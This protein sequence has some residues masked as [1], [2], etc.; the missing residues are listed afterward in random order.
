MAR[1]PKDLRK[2][3]REDFAYGGLLIAL[4]ALTTMVVVSS[5]TSRRSS[6]PAGTS[7]LR[8]PATLR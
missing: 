5:R 6:S 7:R 2:S 1:R 8:A 3:I 4:A